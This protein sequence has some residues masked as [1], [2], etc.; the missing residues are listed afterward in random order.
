[1]SCPQIWNIEKEKNKEKEKVGRQTSEVQREKEL[2]GE[3]KQKEIFCWSNNMKF[4][5]GGMIC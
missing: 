3:K 2:E 4:W 5:S 1:M